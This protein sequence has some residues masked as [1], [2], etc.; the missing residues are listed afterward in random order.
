[1]SAVRFYPD[2]A[3]D[4]AALTGPAVAA[5]PLS[6]LRVDDRST[7][8]RAAA[9]SVAL[10]LSWAAPE[11]IDGVA[12]VHSSLSDS[13]TWRLVGRLAGAVV[14]DTGAAPAL[15]PQ[16]LGKFVWGL[17]PMNVNANTYNAPSN[18]L[19]LRWLAEPV[20]V[21]RLEIY[22]ADPARG[23]VQASRLIA[24]LSWQPAY[25]PDWGVELKQV[26]LG[27][28]ERLGDGGL[29]AEAAPMVKELRLALPV[30]PTIDRNTLFNQ[31]FRRCAGKPLLV[32]A[33]SQADDSMQDADHALWGY[34]PTEKSAKNF[35]H[36]VWAGEIVVQEA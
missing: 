32:A 31:V 12:L 34:L 3:A 26:E 20:R 27:K 11:W 17:D 1:M 10:Q 25:N 18:A 9:A 22:F 29:M 35:A 2:N 5:M 14:F 6:A 30:L 24:G 7:R 16:G 13:A 21:D 23:F 19:A 28:R 33:M 4:R 8:W 15:P 36:Q